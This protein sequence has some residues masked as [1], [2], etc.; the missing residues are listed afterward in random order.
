MRN[1]YPLTA[2]GNV[3][4]RICLDMWAGGGGPPGPGRTADKSG[5]RRR[6]IDQLSTRLQIFGIDFVLRVWG[7]DKRLRFR[8]SDIIHHF[9]V[10]LITVE[11][12]FLHISNGAALLRVV[13]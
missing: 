5:R 8:R 12:L 10:Y 4:H 9:G 13:K 6:G 7:R 3:Q 11:G 1:L 2:V